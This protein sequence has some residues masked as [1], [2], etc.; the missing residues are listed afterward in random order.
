MRKHLLAVAA[1]AM[2]IPAATPSP[3][4]LIVA[5]TP[6]RSSRYSPAGN[7]LTYRYTREEGGLQV[8]CAP[9]IGQIERLAIDRGRAF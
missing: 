1:T 9:R 2:I 4:I 6:S 3:L 5:L 7:E 8:E